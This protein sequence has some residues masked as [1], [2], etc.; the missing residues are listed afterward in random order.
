MMKKTLRRSSGVSPFFIKDYL[1]AA[2][3]YTY[4]GIESV[5]L[6]L[7]E[8]NLKSIGINSINARRR[9]ADERDG[10]EN[11]VESGINLIVLQSKQGLFPVF[12]Q[13]RFQFIQPV[14]FLFWPQVFDHINPDRLFVQVL[15]EIKNIYFDY[16]FC[17]INRWSHADIHH[18]LQQPGLRKRTGPFVLS[19]GYLSAYTPLPERSFHHFQPA[20]WQ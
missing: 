8:Y 7:H 1:L 6:L 13:L 19:N 17:S 16:F 20:G 12:F 11:D 18:S 15:V 5:L 4:E 14:E 10:G 2:K 9:L 3:N